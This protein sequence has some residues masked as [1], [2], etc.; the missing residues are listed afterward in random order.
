MCNK[1]TEI[2]KISRQKQFILITLERKQ[3]EK[4]ENF[5]MRS[6]IASTLHL[7]LLGRSNQRRL[8]GQSI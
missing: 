8:H 5:I 4:G 3:Q 6:F 1:Y 2:L 7:T